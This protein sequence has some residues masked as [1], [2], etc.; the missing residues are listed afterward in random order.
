MD[1]SWEVPEYRAEVFRHGMKRYALGIPVLNEGERLHG[2]LT[3][4][5]DAATADHVDV[6][7]VD[8]GSD[9]GSI[10]LERLRAHEVHAVLIKEGPGALS[11]QLRMFMAEA[12]TRGYEGVVLVDGNGKD[13][14]EAVPDFVTG[15]ERGADYLQGSR[16]LAGGH[17][18]NT[19]FLREWGVRLVHAPLLS[20]ASGVRYTD[21]TNG[22]RA[23]SRRFLLDPRVQPFR[24]LFDTYN[25]HYYL[26]RQ[27]GRLG[28]RVREIPVTRVYPAGGSVPTKISGMRGNLRLFGQLVSTVLG[29]YDLRH[30]PK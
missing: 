26:S 29:R 27:A 17:H 10:D 23:M 11:A 9:D 25:L 14:I 16:Y 7:I 18:E 21:T 20:L 28:F 5:A 12:I 22:F 15:L 1:P 8:G 13:G 4:M 6:F 3:R 19:P 30:P 2:Q 24:A